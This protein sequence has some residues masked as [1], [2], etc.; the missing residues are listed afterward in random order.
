MPPKT[1]EELEA[2]RISAENQALQD[3]KKKAKGIQGQAANQP[4]ISTANADQVTRQQTNSTQQAA[5]S[6]VSQGTQNSTNEST[7][8]QSGKSRSVSQME[9]TPEARAAGQAA[10]ADYM[11]KQGYVQTPDGQWVLNK[12]LFDAL[13]IPRQQ[14]KE[15]RE[16]QEKQNRMKQL[17]AGLYHSGALLSDMISAGVGGNVWKREKDDTAS[18]AAEENKNLRTL[19][20][21]EDAAFA[22]KQRKDLQ[23]TID[24]AQQ[25]SDQRRRELMR[26]VSTQEHKNEGKQSGTSSSNSSQQGYQTNTTVG[27]QTSTSA[28]TYSDALKGG[29]LSGRSRLR[30]SY[31]YG[32]GSSKDADYIP[33]RVVNG[34]YGQEYVSFEVDKNEKAALSNAVARSIDDA[35][36]A[37]DATAQALRDKYFVKKKRTDKAKTWDYDALINDGALYQ[38]PGVLNRYLDEL[39]NMGMTH[40]VNGNEMPYTRDELYDMITG[41]EMHVN[42]PSGV[43]GL[44]PPEPQGG[45]WTPSNSSSESDL[46][47]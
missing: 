17:A 12:T 8:A 10:Y 29:G 13:N 35:A 36:N 40:T 47:N 32:G 30:Y 33:I 42:I 23:N 7:S 16:R 22:E 9:E 5:G 31:G 4:A 28:T 6:S 26:T 19:Q 25:L 46:P 37:G 24:K 14:L 15:E 43:R 44:T 27:Q 39:T 45:G 3:A 2:E 38:V 1:K 20:L 18:K 34:Q 11:T 41:D 21:A